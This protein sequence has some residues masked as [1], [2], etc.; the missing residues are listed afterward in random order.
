MYNVVALPLTQTEKDKLNATHRVH[1]RRA[2]GNFFPATLHSEELYVKT[3]QQPLEIDLVYQKWIFFGHVLRQPEDTPANRA[4]RN[5]YV[6]TKEDGGQ[7][8]KRL[9]RRPISIAK[10]L[11]DELV[12][13]DKPTRRRLGVPRNVV[14]KLP[15][16][17][18]RRLANERVKWTALCKAIAIRA[19]VAWLESY[20]IR[21]ELQV[22]DDRV[23][24]ETSE[25]PRL[26]RTK[27]Y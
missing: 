21:K 27:N 18:L 7:K 8:G 25:T 12:R 14:V 19:R 16:D 20:R 11:V 2:I 4:M 23:A 26:L 22:P 5:Y 10:G 9:G 17:S 24:E 1:L 6:K 15:L 13:L 3:D